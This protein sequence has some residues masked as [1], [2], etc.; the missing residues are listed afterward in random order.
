MQPPP[1]PCPRDTSGMWTQALAL[2]LAEIPSAQD[3]LSSRVARC[4]CAQIRMQLLAPWPVRSEAF[5]V[6]SLA[7]SS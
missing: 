7:D 4:P 1:P 3:R 6:A 2:D 5:S